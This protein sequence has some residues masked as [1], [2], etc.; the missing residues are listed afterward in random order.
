MLLGR[1][2]AAKTAPKMPGQARPSGG[3]GGPFRIN[4]RYGM[5][6]GMVRTVNEN[7]REFSDL[8]T[9]RYGMPRAG[10]GQFVPTGCGMS[11]LRSGTATINHG[12]SDTY[13]TEWADKPGEIHELVACRY[14]MC[15]SEN[16]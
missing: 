4:G 13:D 12:P 10:R 15:R 16:E 1:G 6:Y 9:G 5:G 14:G 11:G 7:T 8:D 3:D 2:T